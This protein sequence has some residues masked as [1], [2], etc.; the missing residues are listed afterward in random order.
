MTIKGLI[1]SIPEMQ[2]S[3]TIAK[4]KELLSQH[5]NT[6]GQEDSGIE[7][8]SIKSL[9]NE[10][11][12]FQGLCYDENIPSNK[13]PLKVKDVLKLAGE[14]I[15]LQVRKESQKETITTTNFPFVI[16]LL[17]I[18]ITMCLNKLI[19]SLISFIR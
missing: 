7:E 6:V 8:K 5:H 19:S 4:S 15:L 11:T 2:P 12:S 9:V 18:V 16:I 14:K 3:A 17:I 13:L 1:G 10:V